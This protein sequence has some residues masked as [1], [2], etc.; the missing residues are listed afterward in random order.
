MI[1]TAKYER[2]LLARARELADL[3]DINDDTLACLGAARHAGLDPEALAGLVGCAAALGADSIESYSAGAGWSGRHAD[4]RHFLGHVASIEDD[5]E[6]R[7][8]AITRLGQQA[9]AA[10]DAAREDLQTARGQLA[11]ARRQLAAA[12][13]MPVHERCNG[14]HARKRAA[15][16]AAEVAVTEA[17]ELVRECEI[18]TGICE[19]ITRTA[20]ALVKQ[21]RHARARIRAVPADLSETYESVY[22]L[23]RR[24]GRMPHQGRWITGEERQPSASERKKS[25]T[26]NPLGGL[27]PD[28]ETEVLEDLARFPGDISREALDRMTELG[29]PKR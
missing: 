10:L 7:L 11:A 9:A 28:Q 2:Q 5:I 14:C 21:L 22:N 24:G 27:P 25:A 1:M 12:H 16:T 17:E 6:E 29:A 15:I 20:D 26:G 23:I 13:T 4:E 3:D 18:R 19:R 8:H